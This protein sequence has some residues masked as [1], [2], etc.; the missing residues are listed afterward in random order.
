MRRAGGAALGVHDN[1]RERMR[2]RFS[3]LGGKLDDY[4]LI[5]ILL[6][7][8]IPR[9]DTNPI[10][11]EL[12]NRFGSLRGVLD[13]SAEQLRTV[14][15]IGDSAA[16]LIKLTQCIS[17]I[18]LE[19]SRPAG[20]ADVID[21]D[22]VGPMMAAKF[23]GH[24]EELAFMLCLN[25]T[26]GLIA[27]CQLSRGDISGTEI[28]LRTVVELAISHAASGV[29]IAHNHPSG[30][31]LPSEADVASTV[32]LRNL[33]KAIDVALVD[34]IIVSGDDWVSMADSGKI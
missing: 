10:A 21:S 11:H 12:M 19:Q 2:S 23:K 22:S 20:E 14:R 16:V 18:Y 13:A 6:F 15:G 29:V 33:L 24:S 26:G 8:A 3:R 27:C 7:Y 31:A 25:K 17:S 4:Q 1:H 32:T 30:V 5:E 9:V 28:S 34:H